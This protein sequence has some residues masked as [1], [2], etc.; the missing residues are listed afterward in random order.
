MDRWGWVREIRASEG[1]G[2]TSPMKWGGSRSARGG[3][4][5]GVRKGAS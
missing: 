3:S 4:G 5:C 1:R 2:N